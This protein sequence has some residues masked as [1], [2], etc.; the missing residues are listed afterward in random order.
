[1]AASSKSRQLRGDQR[2][3][4]AQRG[5]TLR[6]AREARAAVSARSICG[7]RLTKLTKSS[8][9][10]DEQKSEIIPFSTVQAPH[11]LRHA[12]LGGLLDQHR[13]A[14]ALKNTKQKSGAILCALRAELRLKRE[15]H[16][17]L[18]DGADPRKPFAILAIE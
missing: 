7:P 11:H 17:R 12:Q 18:T 6:T 13:Q 16:A 1:M 15:L 4:V 8:S 2:T 5:M 14:S 10:G 3:F 9:C